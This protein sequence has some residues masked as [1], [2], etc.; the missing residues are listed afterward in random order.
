MVPRYH[1]RKA[2]SFERAQSIAVAEK[3]EFEPSAV[4]YVL[5][6]LSRRTDIDF[7]SRQAVDR[8]QYTIDQVYTP[9]SEELILTRLVPFGSSEAVVHPSQ[10]LEPIW[11][12]KKRLHLES[13]LE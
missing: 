3:E 11:H 5:H 9:P 4:L 12:E 13:A 8:I 1:Y 7:L 10:F 6:S 2:G